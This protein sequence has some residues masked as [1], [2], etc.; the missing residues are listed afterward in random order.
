MKLKPRMRLQP[1]L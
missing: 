1:V